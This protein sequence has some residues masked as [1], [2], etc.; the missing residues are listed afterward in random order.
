MIDEP[1][2]SGT[3]AEGSPGEASSG[4]LQGFAPSLPAW[5]L[6][7]MTVSQVLEMPVGELLR[8]LLGGAPAKPRPV[9]KVDIAAA[10]ERGRE[11]ARRQLQR[12]RRGRV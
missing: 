11:E 3:G 1:G 6:G 9:P 7:D 8:M 12:M 2:E 5:A 10:R 4:D